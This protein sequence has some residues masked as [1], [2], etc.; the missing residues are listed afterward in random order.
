MSG[1]NVGFLRSG[2]TRASFNWMGKTP[3][4]NERLHKWHSIG[5]MVVEIRLSNQVGIGSNV[6][7]LAGSVDSSWLISEWY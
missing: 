5:Q 6:Q 3:Y 4:W 1:S 2:V 7:D